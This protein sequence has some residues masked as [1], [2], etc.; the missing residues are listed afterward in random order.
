M[1]TGCKGACGGKHWAL[2]STTLWKAQEGLDCLSHHPL[3][4]TSGFQC[5]YITTYTAMASEIQ[6][7]YNERSNKT[8]YWNLGTCQNTVLEIPEGNLRCDASN[9]RNDTAERDILNWLFFEWQNCFVS[10]TWI[11]SFSMF[12]EIWK[13]SQ[14]LGHT[15]KN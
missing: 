1:S 11:S 10:I 12:E 7:S 3:L 4:V 9:Q 6:V 8:S 2:Q 13:E 15:S 5:P 14:K